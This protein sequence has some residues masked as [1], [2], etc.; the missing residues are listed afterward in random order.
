MNFLKEKT[1]YKL[2]TF[3]T[4]ERKKQLYFLIILLIINGVL[5][6]FSIAT[7][8]PVISIITSENINESIPFIGRVISFFG[9]SDQF[10][11]SLFLTLSF[12]LFVISSTVLRI[13]NISYIYRLSAKVNIDISNLIFR[14]NMYQSY[15]QYT[16]KNSSEIISLALEKVDMASS[17][18][19]YLLTVIASSL[20]G[21]S[22]IISLL[23]I[24]WQV[25]LVGVLFIYFYYF[26]IYQKIKK[27]L[28]RD[29]QVISRVIPL[30]QKILQEGLE[31]YKD[32]IINNLEK[33][34]TKLFNKYH[35]EFKMKQ[36]NL[37]VYVTIPR[38]LIEGI[39][40]SIIVIFAFLFFYS[41]SY[42]VSY[43][44]LI[45]SFI[46]AFQRLL[47]LTQQ[48]YAASANYKYKCTVIKDVVN[49]LEEG[50]NNK[51]LYLSRKKID[52]KKYISFENI[53]FNFNNKKNILNNL[54][55][56]INKGDIIG[57]YGE[58]GSG[59]ST[60]L[61]IIMGLVSPSKGAINVDNINISSTNFIYNWTIN[62]AHVPQK[63]FL[64]EASIEEN[65]AFGIEPKN[66][67][68]DLLVKSAKVANI[69]SFIKNTEK[70]FKTMV[71]ERGIL[72]SGGQRQ[73]IA[74]ARAI[75]KSRKILVLDEAT[76]ALDELTEENIL[77][78]ILNMDKNLTIIM[79]T[80]RINTLNKC[81][82]IFRVIDK[83]I[84]EE[85]KVL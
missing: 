16:N 55:F 13:Y 42:F 17:C 12:C 82:R 51:D 53:S 70:G 64:K 22:I 83:Q 67:D 69:Y 50:K 36:A 2:F 23:I 61:D 71:G 32:V 62:F 54:N 38:T 77:K 73:R 20:I 43:F 27:I 29:G 47:P 24:K 41:N 26:I 48:I 49:D 8:I 15:Y 60:L 72:L 37:N 1:Y 9:I 46:Y 3:F 18:I 56:N 33:I 4:K 81:D 58:T 80:H 79:V 76:S 7:V 68:L 45:A 59:K 6:F 21:I 52:F 14:N 30:R 39:I 25:L 35:A 11:G 84:I 44:P 78:S 75:Y 34:Y 74:I 85:K 65:I 31:G 66:I 63:I 19:D 28:Y 5:E 10:M 57:I 40:I